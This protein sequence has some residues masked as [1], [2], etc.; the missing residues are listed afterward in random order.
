MISLAIG[1]SLLALVFLWVASQIEA[2][3]LTEDEARQIEQ[4][5]EAKASGVGSCS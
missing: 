3:C 2:Q 1:V 5:L 4:Q